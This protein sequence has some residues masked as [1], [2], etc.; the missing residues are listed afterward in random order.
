MKKTKEIKRETEDY[1]D[2]DHLE[3]YYEDLANEEWYH[4]LNT[5]DNE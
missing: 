1:R 4:N 3:R 2:L 5:E